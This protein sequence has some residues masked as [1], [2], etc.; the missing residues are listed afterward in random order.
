MTLPNIADT[1]IFR[2]T[3]KHGA[4]I[5]IAMLVLQAVIEHWNQSGHNANL[6]ARMTALQSKVDMLEQWKE[7]RETVKPAVQTKP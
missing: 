4:A 2:R 5:T 3:K 7:D 6:W 1:Q